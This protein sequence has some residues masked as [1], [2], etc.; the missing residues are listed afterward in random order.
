MFKHETGENFNTYLDKVRI[1]EAKKLLV[2]G[3]KVYE[4]AERVGYAN[5]DYFH[6]KFRKYVGM[7]PA[8]YRKTAGGS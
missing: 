8:A 3:M 5:V 6:G 4:V 2:K 7:S 1:E